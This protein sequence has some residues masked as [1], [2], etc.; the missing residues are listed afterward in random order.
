MVVIFNTDNIATNFKVS[1]NRTV[2]MGQGTAPVLMQTGKVS[3]A[4]KVPTEKKTFITRIKNLF[5]G[6]SETPNFSLYALKIT[7]ERMEK[8]PLK[9][10]D[11][12]MDIEI[13]TSKLKEFS[14][15]FELVSE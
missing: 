11:G 8:I 12:V 5:T 4:F 3:A 9:I 10:R 7:G 14:P 13:D 1:S 15:F 6:K 2:L